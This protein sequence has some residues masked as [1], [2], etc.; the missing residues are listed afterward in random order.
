V[1]DFLAGAGPPGPWLAELARRRADYGGFNLIAGDAGGLHYASNRGPGAQ[2]LAPGVYG[3]SNHRLD[4]P[5]PKVETAKAR[6]ARMIDG[7]D[8]AAE[9]LFRILADQTQ[10]ADEALPATGI[11]LEWERR[12]SAAFIVSP[13]YGTRV[14]TVIL[15]DA[16]GRIEFVERRFDAGGACS[17]EGR[18][19]FDLAGTPD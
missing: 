9:P 17:G 3:L 2:D 19:E 7:A 8:L 11:P 13:E 15:G 16:S 18:F 1:V 10:A 14:S 12:L 5:W 4:T 6:L